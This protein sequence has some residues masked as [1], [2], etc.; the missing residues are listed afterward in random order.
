MP[1]QN[2]RN[3]QEITDFFCVGLLDQFKQQA[4]KQV[5]VLPELF[6]VV[7]FTACVLEGGHCALQKLDCSKLPSYSYSVSCEDEGQQELSLCPPLGLPLCLLYLRL[8]N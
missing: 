6:C 2:H 8:P 1:W 4:A 3:H 5:T 7:E